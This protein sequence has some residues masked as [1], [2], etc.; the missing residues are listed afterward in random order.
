[1][2]TVCDIYVVIEIRAVL[3]ITFDSSLKNL[4][5]PKMININIFIELLFLL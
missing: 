3:T 4:C 5:T 2:N 1:V